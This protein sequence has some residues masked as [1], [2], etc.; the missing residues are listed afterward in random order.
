MEE[1][2]YNLRAP[3][4]IVVDSEGIP[5]HTFFNSEKPGEILGF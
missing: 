4:F 2:G 3:S 5:T 1:G